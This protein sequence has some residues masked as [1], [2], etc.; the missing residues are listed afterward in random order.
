[1]HTVGM[2][3]NQITETNRQYAHGYHS[4][5]ELSNGG[6]VG[7]HP[8]LPRYGPLLISSS[9]FRDF[10]CTDFWQDWLGECDLEHDRTSCLHFG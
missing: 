3:G 10:S 5:L 7:S 6:L 2:T 4:Y 9:S 1:M 8:W